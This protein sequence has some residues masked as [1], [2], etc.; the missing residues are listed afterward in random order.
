MVPGLIFIYTLVNPESTACYASLKRDLAT[1]SAQKRHNET[2]VADYYMYWAIGGLLFNMVMIA[3]YAHALRIPSIRH[4]LTWDGQIKVVRKIVYFTIFAMI[5]FNA[6][7]VAFR[8][9]H[10]FRVCAGDFID[11][12]TLDSVYNG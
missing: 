4:D 11:D 6:T 10:N 7:T 8:W 2:N 3:C 9:E 12:E 1:K 5:I